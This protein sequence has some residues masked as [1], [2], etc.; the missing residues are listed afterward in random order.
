MILFSVTIF[1]VISGVS[2]P[3]FFVET[4]TSVVS[5]SVPFIGLVKTVYSVSGS[6]PSKTPVVDQVSPPSIEYSYPGSTTIVNVLSVVLSTVAF[7]AS[8]ILLIE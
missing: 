6:N 1:A 2:G 4:T 3:D 7:I 5:S 8:F